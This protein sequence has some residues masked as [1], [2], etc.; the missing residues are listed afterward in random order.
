[1]SAAIPAHAETGGSA[2]PGP[3]GC[4]RLAV[5][6]AVE[7]ALASFEAARQ[8]ATLAAGGTLDLVAVRLRGD[9]AADT[10]LAATRFI[11]TRAGI[12]PGVIRLDATDQVAGLLAAAADYDVL[13]VADRRDDGAPSRVADIAARRAPCSVLVARRHAAPWFPAAGAALRADGA[14]TAPT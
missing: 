13:V 2:P 3:A 14:A 1:M 10:H 4:R 9:R 6:C 11:A 12:A 7:P 8:A 5:L